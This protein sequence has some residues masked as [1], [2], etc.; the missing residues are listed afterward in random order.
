MFARQQECHAAVAS[1]AGLTGGIHFE[2]AN[3]RALG[4]HYAPAFEAAAVNVFSSRRRLS[5]WLA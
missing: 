5:R 1:S 2:A 3:Y 4:E